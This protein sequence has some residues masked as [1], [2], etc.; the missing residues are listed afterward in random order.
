MATVTNLP[1]NTETW[2]VPTKRSYD[3]E[4]LMENSSFLLLESGDKIIIIEGANAPTNT[5]K[6]NGSFTNRTKN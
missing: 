1:K 6:N 4:L 2:T 3:D 5:T